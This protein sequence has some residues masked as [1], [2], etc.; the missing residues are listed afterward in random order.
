MKERM[1]VPGRAG[2]QNRWMSSDFIALK[3]DMPRP[4]YAQAMAFFATT[5]LD[6]MGKISRT[7]KEC[8]VILTDES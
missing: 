4:S 3:K 5:L 7:E 1:H 2:L 8:S 6:N